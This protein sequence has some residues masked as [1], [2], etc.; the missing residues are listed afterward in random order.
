MQY[1]YAPLIAQAVD[2]FN[3]VFELAA[4]VLFKEEVAD[5]GQNQINTPERV[6]V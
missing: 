3:G 6:N 2:K 1:D 4:P 5:R